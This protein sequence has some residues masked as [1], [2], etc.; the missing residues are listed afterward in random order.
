MGSE[1][2][3]SESPNAKET[4][5]L[6]PSFI[7]QST[8]A[9][10]LSVQPRSTFTAPSC[11][12]P[13]FPGLRKGVSASQSNSSLLL[14]PQ[15][16]IRGSRLCL[17][18]IPPTL[19][20]KNENETENE[21]ESELSAT[22]RLSIID[23]DLTRQSTGRSR[24]KR[25]KSSIMLVQNGVTG[26]FISS[27]ICKI[28]AKFWH[29]NIE[30][31]SV[32]QQLEIGCSIFFSMLS[33]NNE[34][35]KIMKST[36]LKE[37]KKIEQTSQ[38]YLDMMGW[39][40]RYL[41]TDN[42]DL[43]ALLNKLGG[44]HQSLGIRIQHFTPMLQAMHETFSYYFE[45]KY[46]IEVK[47][48]FDEIFA[49]AAQIMTGQ[50]LNASSHLLSLSEQFQGDE[51]PFLKNLDTCLQ[52]TVGKEYLYR[53]LRQ[54]WCDE[55]VI[56]DKTLSRFKTA[57]GDKARFMIAREIVKTCIEPSAAFAINISYECRSNML[58][59]MR[60]LEEKFASKE[61]LIVPITLFVNVETETRKLI[62]RNHWS[63]FV[64]SIQILQDKSFDAE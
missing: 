25:R 3:H 17:Q 1:Q 56:F 45:D 53:F 32:D 10:S 18:N 50:E 64:E 16:T 54:T 5:K 13:P 12:I 38:K 47:Y 33:S 6:A 43:Y 27:R 22:P 40:I 41:I 52:C 28:A 2:S 9:S 11:E 63:Q 44:I 58:K 8:F 49:L 57:S 37:N 15:S 21:N 31:L 23:R 51:I 42:I 35:K 60:S 55:M 30:N 46:T 7:E 59:S 36:S 29:A 24:H 19:E 4:S 34:M 14:S 61:E 20:E 48:A 26:Q 62:L 39:L